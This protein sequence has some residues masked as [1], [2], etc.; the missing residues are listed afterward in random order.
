MLACFSGTKTCCFREK[1][2][3]ARL[4]FYDRFPPVFFPASCV[5]NLVPANALKHHFITLSFSFTVPFR[6][7]LNTAF[8]NHITRLR[9]LLLLPFV[10]LFAAS[11]AGQVQTPRYNTPIGTNVKGFYEY[12]PQ[13]YDLDNSTYPLLIFMH[14]VGELGNGDATA[15]PKV[16]VNGLPKVIND[17]KF[18]VS[19]TV[20]GATHKFIV[21]SPQFMAWPS[22][23]DVEAV[24]DY[25][26]SHYR[27]NSNRVYL[28]GLSMGGGATW[29]YAGDNSLSANRLAA[30][31]PVCG[32]SYPEPARGRVMAA[33]NLPVWATHNSGDDVVPVSKTHG[34]IAAINQAP[35]PIPA[36]KKT[37]FDVIGHNAWTKTYDP[38]F[39]EAGLNIYEWMLQYQRTA[40]TAGSNSPVCYD[41][42]LRL[43]AW[44]V[45]G[46]TYSWTGPN[47]F[48]ATV[49]EPLIT[50]VT[51]AVAGTYTVTLSKGD[52]TAIA[53]TTVIVT[54]PGTFYKDGDQ[55][56]YGV[57]SIKVNACRPPRGYV[58]RSGDCNDSKSTVYPGAP[59]LCDGLDNN[60]NGQVDEGLPITRYYSDNDKDGW[61]NA[62]IFKDS[63]AQPAGFVTNNTDCNDGKATVYPGALE[64]LDGVDNDCNGKIDD[65]AVAGIKV[66]LY[67]GT[68]PY[69]ASD[70]NNWNVTVSLSSGALKYVNATAS[71]VTATLSN[72]A[73]VTD[74]GTTYGAGMAPAEVLRYASS[75]ST[76]RTLTINGLSASK[77]YNLELYATRNANS[78]YTTVFTTG[79]TSVSIATYKNLSN[80]AAFVNLVPNASGQIAVTIKNANTYSY[81]AGFMLTENNSATTTENLLPT[82]NAS[83]DTTVVLPADSITLIGS[84]SDPDGSITSYQWSQV[85]GPDKAVLSNPATASVTTSALTQGLYTFRLTVTDD[86]GAIAS[87][88]V[89]IT[90]NAAANQAPTAS[91]GA[92]QSISLPVSSVTLSGTGADSDGSVIAYAWTQV[93]GPTQ[94]MITTPDSTS[95]TVSGLD[96]GTYIFRFTVTDNSGA[97]TSDAVVV[98]VNASVTTITKYIK[99]NVYGGIN[100]CTNAE[101]NNW[102]LKSSLKS[103]AFRYSN[104]TTS[105]VTAAISKNAIADN[106]STYGGTMAPPQVLRYSS[107]A[108]VARTLTLSGLSA[109]KTYNLELYA[110]RASTGNATVFTINDSAITILTDN[111]KTVKAIFTN[112]KANAAGQLVISIKNANKYNYLNGFMLTEVSYTT[113]S[114]QRQV[115]ATAPKERDASVLQVQAFPNPA[116]HYLLLHIQSGSSKPTQLRIVDEV[117]RVMETKQGI[118]PNSTVPVGHNYKAGVYFAE[119][120]QENKR[121]TLKLVKQMP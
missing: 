14:G 67:G 112:L 52:S 69:T 84:G 23:A 88:D 104:A 18:P 117:G 90:V 17:G 60:C 113:S 8:I 3:D 13:G 4:P 97:A 65:N 77:T 99:V 81:L 54:T 48:T 121:I 59:E 103:G 68:N 29:D 87:D 28:T 109:S 72:N 26:I 36:A 76:T 95:A 34:Y 61:G 37:I 12:L 40:L 105:T 1:Q 91:A 63:C 100:P 11:G 24:L 120:A 20:A 73:G 55:D 57:L 70:W 75:A 82:A 85:S 45:E 116:T 94:G 89:N 32:S 101:W 115:R 30:I 119:I 25:A 108:S 92:D 78:G 33:A 46:A 19:F 86:S 15:L 102:S 22:P 56:G 64:L 98:L 2:K 9:I 107:Y 96:Q 93:S 31:V 51:D 44:K 43:S 53:S 114:V 83:A 110:S 39:K 106:G 21:I 35:A 6:F 38:L 49:R 62:S 66:N 10:L 111:N 79:T 58:D 7:M 41:S 118:A 27:V 42:V 80:K 5:I 71:A 74:N 50:P 47:G 16:L